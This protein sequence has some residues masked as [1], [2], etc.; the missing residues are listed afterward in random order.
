M[1][2]WGGKG[3]FLLFLLVDLPPPVSPPPANRSVFHERR[4]GMT[5]AHVFFIKLSYQDRV[6]Y[7]VPPLQTSVLL[8]RCSR[9]EN[10]GGE[11]STAAT[12]LLFRARPRSLL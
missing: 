10:E 8:L 3:R 1:L 11:A 6:C 12:V 7:P 9:R 4:K 5:A 2:A